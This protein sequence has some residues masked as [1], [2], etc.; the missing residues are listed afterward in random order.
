MAINGSI[1]INRPPADVFAYLDELGR[2]GEWQ[3]D[4]VSIEVQTEGATRVGSRSRERRKVPGGEREFTYEVTEHEPPKRVSFKGVDGPI[5]PEGTVTLEP[6]ADGSGTSMQLEFDLVPHGFGYLV[7]WLA[8][9]Q[10]R[11]TIP[12]DMANLKQQLEKGA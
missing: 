12:R 1:E 5:R 10:A 9:R 8:R 11:K 7:A 3:E 4:I 6:T 2:H